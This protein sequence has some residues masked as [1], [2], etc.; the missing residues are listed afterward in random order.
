MIGYKQHIAKIKLIEYF[1]YRHTKYEQNWITMVL[2]LNW[3][4]NISYN[5]LL[6]L[7]QRTSTHLVV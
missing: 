3:L 2:I 5:F 6:F 1:H 4:P 7:L